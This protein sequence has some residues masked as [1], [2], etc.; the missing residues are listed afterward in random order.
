MFCYCS[1]ELI[2]ILIMIGVVE[3]YKTIYING[4]HSIVHWTHSLIREP[5]KLGQL[6]NETP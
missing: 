5:Q 3:P 6:V 1:A 2:D 4:H